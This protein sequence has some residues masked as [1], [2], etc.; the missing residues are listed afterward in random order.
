M[1]LFFPFIFLGLSVGGIA[2][3]LF[4]NRERV[5]QAIALIH[6]REILSVSSS[7]THL[8]ASFL[9]TVQRVISQG[10]VYTRL[11]ALRAIAVLQKTFRFFRGGADGRT[12]LTERF[13]NNTHSGLRVHAL[14]KASAQDPAAAVE[15]APAKT[16]LKIVK[17]LQDHSLQKEQEGPL[18][19]EEEFWLGV[20]RQNPRNPHPYKRLAEIY[21]QRGEHAEARA[22]LAYVLRRNPQDEE[23][24]RW[25]QDVRKISIK[26]SVAQA[27]AEEIMPR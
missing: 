11:V 21:M 25:M 16:E 5:L 2:L 12:F 10:A 19:S 20:L 15:A 17:R 7:Q 24:A 22:A 8:A 14:A 18:S 27:D 26:R 4:R 13:E 23:A 3:I 6:H 9:I 1:L